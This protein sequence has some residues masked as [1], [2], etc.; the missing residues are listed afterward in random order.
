MDSRKVYFKSPVPFSMLTG[1]KVTR[2]TVVKHKT[3]SAGA[4]LKRGIQHGHG[5]EIHAAFKTL[6]ERTYYNP[7]QGQISVLEA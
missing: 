2:V 6:S 7:V 3:K 1:V 4:P 5:N